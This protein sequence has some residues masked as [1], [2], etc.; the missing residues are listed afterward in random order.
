VVGTGPR[1]IKAG[2]AVRA[3][4]DGAALA[5]RNRHRRRAVVPVVAIELQ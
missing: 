5:A 1:S 2:R 4:A 3:Q